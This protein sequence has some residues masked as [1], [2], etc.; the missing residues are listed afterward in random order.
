MELGKR[1]LE[2]EARRF[3]LN[4]TTVFES[5]M[6]K[7]LSADYGASDEI[8]AEIGYGKVAPRKL[9]SKL[10][11][12]EQLKEKPPETGMASVVRRV[13]GGG[14]GAAGEDKIKVRGIDD[15]MVVRARC[16]NPIRGEKIVGYITR[17]K[18]VSVHSASA[19]MS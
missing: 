9:L 8:F 1:M 15:L 2:M 10:V 17:G 11:P 7:K 12:Q 19:R 13:L 4:P 5:E 14:S 16:C 3:D 18:G 6:L